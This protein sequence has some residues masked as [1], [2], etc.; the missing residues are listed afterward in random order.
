MWDTAMQQQIPQDRL[1]RVYSYDAL[2]SF[3]CIP[4]GLS[5]AGPL[6]DLLGVTATLVFAGLVTVVA[7]GLVLLVHDVRTLREPTSSRAAPRAPAPSPRSQVTDCMAGRAPCRE[8]KAHER[9]IRLV[10]LSAVRAA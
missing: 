4:I 9:P 7:T 10:Q 8:H 3:V 5:V 1:S 6:S 2:G